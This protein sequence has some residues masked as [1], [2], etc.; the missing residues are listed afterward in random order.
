MD[1]LDGG[2]SVA[3]GAGRTGQVVTSRGSYEETSVVSCGWL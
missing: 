1:E 2:E 3:E